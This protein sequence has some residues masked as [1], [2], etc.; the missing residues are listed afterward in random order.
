MTTRARLLVPFACCAALTSVQAAAFADQA[1]FR[2]ASNDVI[3]ARTGRT[4]S[5]ADG[6]DV[7]GIRVAFADQALRLRIHHKNLT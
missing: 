5:T 2:D 6:I 4:T 3:N 1:R 7:R